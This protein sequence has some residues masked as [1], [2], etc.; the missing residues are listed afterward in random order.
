MLA[1]VLLLAGCASDPNEALNPG[2]RAM[3][4]PPDEMRPSL[5]IVT[6][7]QPPAVPPDPGIANDPSKLI[8]GDF[9]TITFS[10]V[11]APGLQDV[12]ARIPSDG[13]ITLHYN[14]RVKAAGKNIA[15]LQQDI[16]KAY[17]PGLFVNLTVVVK[18]EDRYF[19]VGGE[20]RAPSR[21]IYLGNVTV[22]RAIETASG[23]TDFAKRTKIQLR[24]ANGQTIIVNAI[25][26][27]KDPSLDPPVLPNDHITVPRT[28]WA[29]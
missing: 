10:D 6:T 13:Y 27:E 20:V 15:D 22:L 17:V 18:A 3:V 8:V 25:K 19:Y 7:G 24:R 16:R 28:G 9:L 26:A 5:D 4:F 14:V 21:Q 1:A 29:F 12:R 11:P 2:K 23:F